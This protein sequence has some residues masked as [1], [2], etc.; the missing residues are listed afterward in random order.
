M[1]HL[2]WLQAPQGGKRQVLKFSRYLGCWSDG[3]TKTLDTN[4]RY[5]HAPL[6]SS[7]PSQFLIFLC[8]SFGL[9]YKC[10]IPLATVTVVLRCP[11]KSW[12]AR[13]EMRQ[14][15]RVRQTHSKCSLSDIETKLIAVRKAYLW[16][17]REI[18]QE[19]N[20]NLR[21][22]FAWQV[23]SR[24]KLNSTM[25]F[26]GY[27]LIGWRRNPPRWYRYWRTSYGFW[28]YYTG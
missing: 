18:L 8:P 17:G 28:G 22:T 9:L 19:P 14:D 6:Y 7:I 4:S 13:C 23:R 12:Q 10:V 5:A 11:V 1:Q 3:C 15:L 25:L 27:I 24:L 2:R 16:N 21:S 20:K 26:V